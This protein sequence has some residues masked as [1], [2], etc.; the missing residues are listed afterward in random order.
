MGVTEVPVD[1]VQLINVDKK[2]YAVLVASAQ[3]VHG[4]LDIMSSK[5]DQ[6]RSITYHTL[7]ISFAL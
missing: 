6:V 1:P 2:E 7:C 5:Y 4:Q 3:Q